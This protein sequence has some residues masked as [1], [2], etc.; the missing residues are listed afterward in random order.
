MGATRASKLADDV[1]MTAQREVGI[2]AVLEAHEPQLFEMRALTQ[3]E[4]LGELGQRGAAP[5]GER[6]ARRSEAV[7]ASP[8]ASAARPSLRSRMNCTTSTVSGSTSSA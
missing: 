2:D 8:A 7:S 6:P 5:Q 1:G 3:G 4:R